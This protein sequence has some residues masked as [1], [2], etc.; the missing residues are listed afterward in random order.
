MPV[1]DQFYG[2]RTGQV[3][4]PYGHIWSIATHIEDVSLE[5]CKARM[6]K[7]FTAAARG[8]MLELKE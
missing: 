2:D 8:M 4:D 1:S 3:V 5:E 7:L 6:E